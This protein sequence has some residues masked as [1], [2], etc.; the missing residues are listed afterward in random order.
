MSEESAAPS[1]DQT[2]QPQLVSTDVESIGKKEKFTKPDFG[3]SLV[4]TK[5]AIKKEEMELTGRSKKAKPIGTP[6][7]DAAKEDAPKDFLNESVPRETKPE[8]EQEK[9]PEIK[10]PPAEPKKYKVKVDGEEIEVTE[11]V[12]VRDYQIRK[13]SDKRFQE[14]AELDKRNQTLLKKIKD[15]QGLVEFLTAFGLDPDRLAEERIAARLEYEMMTPEQKQIF[16]LRQKN[17][18]YEAQQKQAQAARQREEEEKLNSRHADNLQK[19]IIASLDETG[20]LPKTP[21]TI[22]LIV[23]HMRTLTENGVMVEPR[24]VL[25]LVREELSGLNR[26]IVSKMTPEQLLKYLG[27][28]KLDEYRQ[29]E[30]SKLKNPVQQTKDVV[31]PVMKS[32][33]KRHYTTMRE[34]ERKMAAI[35]GH[36]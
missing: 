21:E 2:T 5:S 10:P 9:P 3:K 36:R 15:P 32:E 1:T 25:D 19:S 27:K 11:D 24:D 14:A 22:R 4:K 26:N 35:K 34:F 6:S 23:K 29:W 20:D 17:S 18:M 13:A 30:L 33:P 28:E 31:T 8:Q 12:L 16:E 7:D